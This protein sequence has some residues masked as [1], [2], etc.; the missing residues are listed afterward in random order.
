[1]ESPAVPALLIGALF[2]EKGLI[3]QEQ[4]DIALEEQQ[5]TGNRLGEVLV[6][7]FGVSR[8]D[9]ASALAE[10]WAEYERQGTTEQQESH[11]EVRDLVAVSDEWSG[12]PEDADTDVDAAPKRPIGEIF[13]ERGMISADELDLA[14]EEQ[15]ESGR[16][17]GEI[18]V[19]KGNLSRLELASALADQWAS[20]Q[21]LRPPSASN[22]VPPL[23]P[24]DPVPTPVM[25]TPEVS[26][27]ASAV[28]G[29][30]SDQV[31]ALRARLEA[32]G[33]QLDQLSATTREWHEPL[34]EL[35]ASIG[36]R[37]SAVEQAAA[38]RSADLAA[39][40]ASKAEIAAIATR[41]DELAAS[42]ATPASD[43][44]PADLPDR[45]EKLAAA[46]E[47]Q[48][49]RLGDL[50][51][52][53]QAG[54]KE[55]GGR[56][57]IAA[58][59][60]RLEALA[61]P[62]AG[63]DELRASV[64][65]L[66]SRVEQ[67]V[68]SDEWREPFE[69][70]ANDLRDRI[71]TI[72]QTPTP[73]ADESTE[74]LRAELASLTARIDAIPV[75]SE[76]WR[77]E[78]ASLTARLDELMTRPAEG[79]EE[80]RIEIATLEARL[81]AI[82]AQSEEWKT[83]LGQ[84]AEN[85]RARFDRVEADLAA[86][87][88]DG[89]SAEQLEGLR[90]ELESLSSR[91]ASI[92]APSDEWRDRS[93]DLTA[94]IDALPV[95]TD[96]WKT[97]LG[98]VA[99]NLRARFDRVE[100]DLAARAEGGASAE[101]LDGLRYALGELAGRV[102]AIP[103]PS[104]DWRIELGQVAENLRARFD[105]VEA[106]L[107]A[108][109]DDGAGA[110]LG[111]RLAELAGR[112]PEGFEGLR[113]EVESLSSR[114]AAIPAPNEE[115]RDG[116][117]HLAARIDGLPVPTDEWKTELGQVAENLRARF[118]RVE[119]DLAAR[120]EDGSVAE[121]F[122]DIRRT[123]AELASRVDALPAPNEEWRDGLRAL[124]TRL[125][126]LP[127]PSEDWRE[128]LEALVARVDAIP[129]NLRIR[130]DR[131]DH[132]LAARAEH[133][134]IADLSERLEALANG[135]PERFG[136]LRASHSQLSDRIDAIPPPSD[137]WRHELAQVAENL[138]TRV[139][140]VETGL[141]QRPGLDLL[142]GL[143]DEL[144]ALTARIDA[145]LHERDE[146]AAGQSAHVEWLAGRLAQTEGLEQHLRDELGPLVEGSVSPLAE[147]LTG[148]EGS[149]EEHKASAAEVTPR[150]D[151]LAERL[152]KQARRIEKLRDDGPTAAQVAEA[153][154]AR[155]EA[156]EAVA[157]DAYAT[158]DERLATLGGQ[159]ASASGRAASDVESLRRELDDLRGVTVAAAEAST[160]HAD[161]LAEQLRNETAANV[162]AAFAETDSRGALE[163]LDGLVAGQAAAFEALQAGL[164]ER[165]RLSDERFSALERSQAKRSDV[166]ELRDAL[167]R[168]E[169]HIAAETAKE[170][171]RVV[172][173]EGAV[174]EGL[175]AL[176]SR[177]SESEGAYFQAGDSL[178]RSIEHLGSA[179][180]GADAHR[181]PSQDVSEV[182]AAATSF[183]A[184]A[185]TS[186]GYRLVELDGAAPVVGGLVEVPGFETP[187]VVARLGASPLPFDRRPCAYLELQA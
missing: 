28:P 50:A 186:E 159:V 76:D 21:K 156:S 74:V 66:A 68:T 143:R 24:A 152:D 80:L 9:L 108:R 72:E 79:V 96:E 77:A 73:T 56:N 52:K 53:E 184:F 27:F 49:A 128:A 90:G 33:A 63:L 67:P 58:L 170:D 139:E 165:E 57:E 99:E 87:A 82:P 61:Q 62:V 18:L 38:D 15:R 95:P 177:M 91:V 180:R 97:E 122:D 144:Q 176:A 14:L 136:E 70:L 71:S 134:A 10:Q 135:L 20:F 51:A 36:E 30:A 69:S 35:S 8:L 171:T 32:L 109:A 124:T 155:L 98:Q 178:R 157:T 44:L 11:S 60:A 132:D 147:R 146:R 59:E 40:D 119:A 43:P 45:V 137:E 158:L 102:D 22:G 164:D 1:M 106:D 5:R 31:D 6:E 85:L 113:G 2:V 101:Q 174:R 179:I 181:A 168:V 46:I 89:A 172:A 151:D 127:I 107:G 94:R 93:A 133:V 123:L 115:W 105:R 4:L 118:D 83:E 54:G 16:R 117:A 154:G 185:P 29:A 149:L 126:E 163:R 141:E 167:G 25:P 104:E 142:A 182:L 187:F 120:A 145:D 3:T 125:D 17:L 65:D 166:R 34:N 169:Q 183:L 47:Q 162:A 148:I 138:R 48:E 23:Q 110:E 121:R 84:V 26:S 103:A 86:R 175:V 114:V 7:R 129:D 75:P 42:I 100:A 160:A 19:G 140:R 37:L 153:L 130:L 13:L 64:T 131:V 55:R 12:A 39:E 81:S 41:V 112:V 150:L 111:L 161:H 78:I 92:P 173:V 116:L 88:G